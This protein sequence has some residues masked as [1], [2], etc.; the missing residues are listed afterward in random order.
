MPR[1]LILFACIFSFSISLT[2]QN[3]ITLYERC[4]Y[5]GQYSNLEP[6]RYGTRQMKI[7]NDKLSSMRIPSGLKITIYEHDNFAGRSKTFTSDVSCL[8][9]EWKNMASSVIVEGS[10]IEPNNNNYGQNDYINF[11][12]DCYYRGYSQSLRP[13]SYNG[14]QLGLLEY[15]ISSFIIHGN[16]RVRAYVSNTNLWGNSY[17]FESD[18]S[19][20]GSAQNDKIGSLVIEYKPRQPNNPYHV[21]NGNYATVY[22]DCNFQGNS[23][24]LAPGSYQGD[25]L[26]LLKY[27]ISS[28]EIPSNLRAKVFINSEYLSGPYYLVTENSNCLSSTLNNRIGS[29]IIEETGYN[30]NN[31]NPYE[32]DNER[33]VI[34]V[35]A[36]FRGQSVIVPPGRYSNMSQLGFPDKALSSLTVPPGYRVVLY[37]LE[38]FGGK[39]YTII[40]SKNRFYFSGW[41]DKTSSIAVYRDR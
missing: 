19:C 29:L 9:P 7:D 31:N 36:D 12:N 27:D 2:A 30:N 16:L 10:H 14:S 33:V 6:G 23:L 24:R 22:T 28:I 18:Q 17:T 8:E 4:N 26:G 39:S 41:N 15:N 38:N 37:E 40:Q 21:A 11:F 20:L 5:S 34:Y 32:Q 3:Y 35:D 1:K 25:K 13:G